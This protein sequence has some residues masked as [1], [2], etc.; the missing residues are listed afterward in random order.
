MKRPRS[1][2]VADAPTSVAANL[3]RRAGTVDMEPLFSL[4]RAISSAVDEAAIAAE[5]ARAD[6]SML[7]LTL[8]AAV[9]TRC[10]EL[11]SSLVAAHA[12]KKA[13]LE[14]ELVGVDSAITEAKREV[15]AVLHIVRTLVDA[16]LSSLETDAL[17]ATLRARL[18]AL[19]ADIALTDPCP[20][21]PVHLK[22]EVDATAIV[23]T[24]NAAARIAAPRGVANADLASALEAVGPG[25]RP[26]GI[27]EV[28]LRLHSPASVA[29]HVGGPLSSGVTCSGIAAALAS[30][31][32]SLA[33]RTRAEALFETSG[34]A[35]PSLL[36]VRVS[37][38]VEAEG[39]RFSFSV[40][41]HATPGSSVTLGPVYVSG[42][43]LALPP[44]RLRPV[45][46]L[47]SPL[48]IAGAA[49]ANTSLPAVSASGRLFV[50]LY[51]SPDIRV[52][53]RDGSPEE[54]I[55]VE[56]LGLSANTTAVALLRGG[57]DDD[58]GTSGSSSSGG[59]GGGGVLC[60][61]DENGPASCVV[62]LDLRS[63]S[64]LWRTPPGL[65][66]SCTGIAALPAAGVVVATSWDDAAL[67]VLC[68]QTGRP[69]GPPLR[70]AGHPGLPT[71]DTRAGAIYVVIHRPCGLQ[72]VE[73]F[74]WAGGQLV[75]EGPVAAAQGVPTGE[76][77]GLQ[78]DFVACAPSAGGPEST[79]HLI[80]ALSSCGALTRL[81][82]L[83]LPSHALVHETALDRSVDVF[84][85]AASAT[86]LVV[87]DGAA[88][89]ALVL[90]WPLPGAPHGT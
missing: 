83:A 81:R 46:G 21:E 72:A 51:A 11:E 26:G 43:P 54:P 62:A 3:L 36:P 12:A 35:E 70:C 88:G 29:L 6:I 69:L 60:V 59:G 44:L 71:A 45:F 57:D 32:S 4:G 65:L 74:A 63:R 19:E 27:F 18:D 40:P 14:S 5:A 87:C 33:L 17:I 8:H 76:G 28:L 22:L 73:R 34:G 75:A 78:P 61:S 31:L 25:A 85:L 37:A 24:I 80:V 64:L 13:E 15:E 49:T 41:M 20:K 56:L 84:G 23:S 16:R 77:R 55:P 2:P 1:P 67:V 10:D 82:V 52:F 50:P 89:A 42:S 86:A 9:D 39:I 90:P 47:L 48:R 68:A 79:A 53:G 30:S 7:R 66:Q 58:D 38:D